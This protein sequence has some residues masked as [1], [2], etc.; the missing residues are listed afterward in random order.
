[1]N[2][3]DGMLKLLRLSRWI[4]APFRALDNR[5]HKR[6]T[7]ILAALGQAPFPADHAVAEPERRAYA[8]QAAVAA[9]EPSFKPYQTFFT[10]TAVEDWSPR[11]GARVVAR[12]WLDPGYRSRL[13]KNGTAACAELGY[14]GP[15]GE[16]IVALEN[17]PAVH[18]LIVCTL[19]SCT[20]WPVLGLPPDWYKSFAYR[21]RV[22]RESR[23]VLHEMGFDPPAETE[24]RVWDTTAETRYLVLPMRPAD[25]QGW[26]EKELAAVVTREAMIGVAPVLAKHAV[27]T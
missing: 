11:N 7:R 18:N 3:R 16:Y 8:L 24:I 1:M 9:R 13:L 22:V 21:S 5:L 10:K 17:T 15:Q 19:C 2:K 12:A 25:T 26:T 6:Q 23:A 14:S 4:Q 20:A 27:A